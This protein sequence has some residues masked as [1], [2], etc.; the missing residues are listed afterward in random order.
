MP[1]MM[2][3]EH[4][5]F[6]FVPADGPRTGAA[7]ASVITAIGSAP[8]ILALPFV[9]DGIWTL[10]SNLT[11]PGNIVL[12]IPPGVTV[13]RSSGVTLD[14]QGKV[15]AFSQNWATG[16]GTTTRN[17]LPLDHVDISPISTEHIHPIFGLTQ[18]AVNIEHPTLET[19]VNLYADMG[20]GFPGIDIGRSASDST[21][22]WRIRN[23]DVNNVLAFGHPGATNPIVTF[24]SAGVWVGN[25]AS[26]T[27]PFHILQAQSSDVV[28]PGGGPW[29]S[30]SDS[31]V[32]TVEAPFTDGLDTLIAL[33]APVIYQYNGKGGTVIDDKNYV[34]MIAQDVQPVT[35][36]MVYTYEAKLEETDTETTE[37]LAM[38]NGP[39]VYML[40][41]AVRELATR[42]E[43]LE[44]ALAARSNGELHAAAAQAA[45]ARHRRT[46]E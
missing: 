41:N 21:V 12:W 38:N 30:S 40:M 18:P 3:S 42:V 15:F 25:G 1:S 31:R 27:T 7:I 37:I 29:G 33:P 35:P 2:A 8:A 19:F 26:Y 4:M 5:G 23:W 11:I 14:M 9:G 16:P 28:Y 43:T 13:F 17:V 6:R 22:N 46:K 10:T 32:K 44:A 20:S 34:G 39:M 45:P 36:Y 24:T